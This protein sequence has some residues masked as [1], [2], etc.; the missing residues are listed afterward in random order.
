M[1]IFFFKFIFVFLTICIC[2]LGMYTGAQ[3]PERPEEGTGS[4][5]VSYRQLCTAGRGCWK[6]NLSPL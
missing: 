4:P 3:L 1:P 5:D 6:L 2:V